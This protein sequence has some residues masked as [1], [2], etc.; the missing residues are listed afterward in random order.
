MTFRKYLWLVHCD[1]K[2]NASEKGSCRSTFC[3]AVAYSNFFMGTI[4]AAN[5]AN[6]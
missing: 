4:I 5:F 6:L 2:D 3:S 1:V